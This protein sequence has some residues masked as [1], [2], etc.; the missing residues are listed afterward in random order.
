MDSYIPRYVRDQAAPKSVQ[1]LKKG[2]PF[3]RGIEERIHSE[4]DYRGG[5]F[6]VVKTKRKNNLDSGIRFD[7]DFDIKSN[8]TLSSGSG[9]PREDEVEQPMSMSVVSRIEKVVTSSIQPLKKQFE[10]EE[11]AERIQLHLEGNL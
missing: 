2:R 5:I 3:V 6:K 11:R 8:K 7:D 9:S 10:D 1:R 4:T